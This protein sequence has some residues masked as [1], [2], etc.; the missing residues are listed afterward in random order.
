MIAV[1]LR[2]LILSVQY[3]YPLIMAVQL[4]R[5]RQTD[6]SKEQITRLFTYFMIQAIVNLLEYHF[7]TYL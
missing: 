2:G 3:I 6:D 1:W 4:L 7:C 5:K